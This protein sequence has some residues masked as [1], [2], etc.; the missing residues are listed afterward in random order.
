M[1]S[2]KPLVSFG[3]TPLVSDFNNDGKP[4]LIWAN[5]AGK[6]KAYISSGG[7]GNGIKVQLPNQTRFLGAKAVVTDSAGNTQI[8]QLIAG[9]G[10]GSD[11]SR[12]MIFGLGTDTFSK[13]VITLLDGTTKTFNAAP[14][15]VITWT[16]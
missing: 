1:P 14:N 2:I 9:E 10:L 16:P 3:I 15:G 11:Q 13:A 12:A 4:D 8:Q 5:I 6:S 7:T